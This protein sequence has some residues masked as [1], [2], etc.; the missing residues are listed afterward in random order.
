MGRGPWP[1]SV[2]R[3]SCIAVS[4]G[5]GQRPVL[6]WLWHRPAA[7]A[8]IIPLAW[9]LPYV[10][11]VALKTKKN[12]TKTKQNKKHQKPK[13]KR[14]TTKRDSTINMKAYIN[15]N[16]NKIQK[17]GSVAFFFSFWQ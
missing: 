15:F 6:L 4:C 17:R 9:Q 8:P 3:G 12:Q 5:V 13:H 10:T 1:H 2:G 11:G 14:Q 16:I 7:V